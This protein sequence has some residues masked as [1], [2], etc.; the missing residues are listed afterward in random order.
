MDEARIDV[1][2]LEAMFLHAKRRM[3]ELKGVGTRFLHLTDSQVVAGVVAKG[4]S[5]SRSLNGIVR[6]MG[7]LLLGSHS[8]CVVGWVK[9]K[10]NPA[11]LPSRRFRIRKLHL[12]GGARKVR[13]RV[14]P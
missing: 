13:I 14:G 12:K 10:E 1:L 11:D 6:R 4:R 3:R 7:A 5:S 8:Y 2:E 9:T